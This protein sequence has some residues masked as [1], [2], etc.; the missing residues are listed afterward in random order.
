MDPSLLLRKR[1]EDKMKEAG[2][3]EAATGRDTD[4]NGQQHL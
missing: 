4:I 2:R 1:V 3:I